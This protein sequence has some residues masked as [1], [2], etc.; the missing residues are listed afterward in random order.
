[1]NYLDLMKD[2]EATARRKDLK[3]IEQLRKLRGE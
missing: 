1:M 2:K 3:D